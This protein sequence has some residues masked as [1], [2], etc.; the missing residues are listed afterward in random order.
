MNFF[1]NRIDPG[2]IPQIGNKFSGIGGIDQYTKLM[3]HFTDGGIYDDS[4]FRQPV[5]TSIMRLI[6]YPGYFGGYAGRFV[7]T[8][9]YLSFFDSTDWYFDGDF[10]IDAWVRIAALPAGASVKIM[11]CGQYKD[12]SNYIYFCVRNDGTNNYD[13]YGT[14]YNAGTPV[15]FG[16]QRPAVKLAINTWYHIAWV[17][18]GNNHLTFQDGVLLGTN[19]D[20]DSWPNVDSAFF[21]GNYGTGTAFW[22]GWV[23]EFRVSK[24]IARWTANF[25]PPVAP[26][27][28]KQWD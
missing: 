24:G 25:T 5:D 15:A 1:R 22:N 10:T 13:W 23:N 28:R 12:A 21:I 4:L 9:H 6:N 19:E 11:L 17:R 14:G 18:S 3:L 27:T 26:Y 16:L 7:A 20:T 8:T 2:R